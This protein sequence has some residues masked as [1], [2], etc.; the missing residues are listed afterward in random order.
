MIWHSKILLFVNERLN[1][2]S[3][4]ERQALVTQILLIE[5]AR[6]LMKYPIA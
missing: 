3:R 5:L 6:P 1:S 4:F 2:L